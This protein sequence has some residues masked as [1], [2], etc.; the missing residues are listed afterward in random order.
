MRITGKQLRRII[1]EEVAR[2]VN[3]EDGPT[4][5]AAP[6]RSPGATNAAFSN[7][8]LARLTQVIQRAGREALVNAPIIDRS[9][10]GDLLKRVLGKLMAGQ[11]FS[12]RNPDP[13]AALVVNLLA[14]GLARANPSNKALA[15]AV[16]NR[17][18]TEEFGPLLMKLQRMLG[19]KVDGVLGTQSYF[20]LLSGGAINLND[21]LEKV[22]QDRRA[23]RAAAEALLKSLDIKPL[24]FG[25]IPDIK[26]E[27][28][29]IDRMLRQTIDAT[30]SPK[31]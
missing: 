14:T 6:A 17:L 30:P 18:P 13:E 20:A 27:M 11:Y 19:I 2:M 12:D 10:Y 22:V 26:S 7:P 29:E 9:K 31:L 15:D 23:G 3:E 4:T 28:E 5:G 21:P 25:E 24:K 16:A 8:A 1:Q